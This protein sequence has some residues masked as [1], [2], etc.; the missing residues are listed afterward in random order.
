MKHA[1][2]STVNHGG[3]MYALNCTMNALNYFGTKADFHLLYFGT[4]ISQGYKDACSSAFPFKVIWE[5]SLKYGDSVHNAKYEYARTLKGK[6]D[7]VCLID[8]DYSIYTD[9]T[10]ILERSAREDIIISGVHAHGMKRM[11]DDRF[12]KDPTLVCSI[13]YNY[14]ADFPLCVNPNLERTQKLLLT[15][16]KST[17]KKYSDTG[18]EYSK[19]TVALNRAVCELYNKDEIIGLD[20]NQ[21]LNDHNTGTANWN[22]WGDRLYNDEGQIIY[23]IHHKWWKTGRASAI[24]RGHIRITKDQ[25]FQMKRLR[26]AEKNINT[27]N[28]Y[29]KCWNNMTPS[30]AWSSNIEHNYISR[31]K[32]LKE[33]NLWDEKIHG[34]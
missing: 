8:G 29:M 24:W 4:P 13:R 33:N 3:Y 30:T 1:I 16:W 31:V 14:L 7:S 17:H 26:Q 2:I 9:I 12:F 22:L 6:Y 28:E 11:F 15:W 19:P 5:P 10:D 18:I 27:V 23:A 34:E 21:W 20:H 25:I 32:H